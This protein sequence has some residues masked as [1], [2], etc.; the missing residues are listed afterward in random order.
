M[1]AAQTRAARGDRT[2]PASAQ[3]WG[4]SLARGGGRACVPGMTRWHTTASA[5]ARSTSSWRGTPLRLARAGAWCQALGYN[6]LLDN[7]TASEKAGGARRASA[8]TKRAVSAMVVTPPRPA[9]RSSARSRACCCS[10]PSRCSRSRAS[11][12]RRARIPGG[13]SATAGPRQRRP[14]A[15][16]KFGPT[17][18]ADTALRRSAGSAGCYRGTGAPAAAPLPVG[19]ALCPGKAAP[20]QTATQPVGGVAGRFPSAHASG[21]PAHRASPHRSPTRGCLPRRRGRPRRAAPPAR[22]AACARQCGRARA[23]A[24]SRAP[25]A[26][27]PAG[28]AGSRPAAPGRTP[29]PPARRQSRLAPRS[30]GSS[31]GEGGCACP[32]ANLCTSAL[33]KRWSPQ[34]VSFFQGKSFL[35]LPAASPESLGSGGGCGRVCCVFLWAARRAT[36]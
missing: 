5:C 26:P 16:G 7:R 2:S 27:A 13:L 9:A 22:R 35:L 32:P 3:P 30:T 8:L 1:H 19:L 36:L 6:P 21:P 12:A 23:A 20:H 4:S 28:R 18:K 29:G 15:P 11:S 34:C 31:P 25:R 14:K 24:A 10:S 33:R 17:C